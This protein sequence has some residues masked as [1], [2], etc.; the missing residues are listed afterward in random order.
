MT[1]K[2]KTRLIDAAEELGWSVSEVD[3][4]WEFETHSPAGED[5]IF[6]TDGGDDVVAELL[7]YYETFDP[8]EHATDLIIAKRNGLSGVP[9]VRELI[10]DAEEIDQMLSDLYDALFAAE[11]KYYE[12]CEEGA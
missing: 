3:G 5:F 1:E 12:E 2:L 10:D 6:Y 9:S 7:L 8:N 11:E 4:C